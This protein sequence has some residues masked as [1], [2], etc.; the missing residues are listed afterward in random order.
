VADTQKENWNL[1]Y[2][3]RNEPRQDEWLVA[4]DGY[5]KRRNDF[6][7]LDLGCGNGIN[8]PFLL[9]KNR[10]VYACDYSEEAIGI[11]RTKF[12]ID[13]RIVDIRDGLPYGN[14][15]FDIIVSD[16]SL[17]YFSDSTTKRILKDI[18]RVLRKDGIVLVRVNSINDKNHGFNK[19]EEIEA[20]FFVLKGRY[21]RF[22]DKNAIEMYF[23]DGF[24]IEKIFERQTSKYSAEKALWEVV[25]R[26]NL[27]LHKPD[28]GSA[29]NVG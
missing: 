26:K 5:F 29:N 12:D 17:H 19:G 7:V 13:A 14:E 11:V 9:S 1:F 15:Q 22:F 20:N 6:S 8:I 21:K 2:K 16:L 4:Y 25:L 27:Q 10:N 23:K 24:S 28:S 3:S 18:F